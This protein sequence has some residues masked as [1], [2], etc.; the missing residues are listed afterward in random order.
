[1]SVRSLVSQSRDVLGLGADEVG[2][3]PEATTTANGG[4]VAMSGSSGPS[5]VLV[6]DMVLDMV[7]SSRG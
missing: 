5:T 6:L 1:M 7:L 2:C 3:R 4:A